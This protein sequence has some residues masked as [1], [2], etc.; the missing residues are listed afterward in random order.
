M[1]KKYWVVFNKVKQEIVSFPNGQYMVFEYPVQASSY[2][3]RQ[4]M[5]SGAFEI[6]PF[7][8]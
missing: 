4:L 5:G 2:I 1:G 6:R 3:D 8:K 7:S